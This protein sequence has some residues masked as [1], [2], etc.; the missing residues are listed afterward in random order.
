MLSYTTIAERVR[1]R[2]RGRSGAQSSSPRPVDAGWQQ[3]LKAL[4][5]RVEHLES[6][7]E[8]LQDAVHRRAVLEDE[9]IDE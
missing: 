2:W 6:A 3:Q 1:R 8:G 9:Q 7:L 5:A 4:E